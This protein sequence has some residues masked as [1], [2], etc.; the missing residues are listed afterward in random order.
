[1]QHQQNGIGIGSK[2]INFGSVCSRLLSTGSIKIYRFVNACRLH[3]PDKRKRD[4][5]VAMVAA[6]TSPIG[7]STIFILLLHSQYSK[8][9]IYHNESVRVF[10]CVCAWVHVCKCVT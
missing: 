4:E 6:L 7:Q 3:L 1:M 5:S 2:P 10:V 8:I 9:Q